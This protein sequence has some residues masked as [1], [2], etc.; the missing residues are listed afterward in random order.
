[1]AGDLA[2][3]HAALERTKKPGRHPAL[4][5]LG[6]AGKFLGGR[7]EAGK[8]NR[9]HARP[10]NCLKPIP[11]LE[12]QRAGPQRLEKIGDGNF[13]RELI[14]KGGEMGDISP[15]VWNK[16]LLSSPRAALNATK[17]R[18]RIEK[19]KPEPSR[20]SEEGQTEHWGKEKMSKQ[21]CAQGECARTPSTSAARSPREL[22][23]LQEN[24]EKKDY[25][26]DW[27]KR[28]NRRKQKKKYWGKLERE[29]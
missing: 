6:L 19:K 26:E 12:Q 23:K 22:E 13:S 21:T 8:E 24:A 16:T 18:T 14:Q 9:H 4:H 29:T 5:R 20:A 15:L 3:A 17:K 2:A 11:G 7:K 1:M 27:S 28:R 10:M 25:L